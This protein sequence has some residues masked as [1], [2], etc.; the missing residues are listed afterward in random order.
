METTWKPSAAS[1]K[2]S[3]LTNAQT[4]SEPL[5]IL[6]FKQDQHQRGVLDTSRHCRTQIPHLAKI[7][8]CERKLRSHAAPALR[9]L[10]RTARLLKT[11]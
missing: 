6:Q 8:V 4:I 3:R 2:H 5:D 9:N 11:N 10:R 7:K 1:L